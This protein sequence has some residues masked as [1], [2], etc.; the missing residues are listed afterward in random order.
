M[1]QERDDSIEDYEEVL[2]PL[3]DEGQLGR[4][5]EDGQRLA[6]DDGR[7]INSRD[8]LLI[9]IP[10]RW[11]LGLPVGLQAMGVVLLC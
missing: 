4:L 2:R 5:G 6:R 9:N 7:D 10:G 11:V 8:E 3:R 1:Q